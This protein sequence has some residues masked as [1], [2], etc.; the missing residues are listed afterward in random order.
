MI[1]RGLRGRGRG[2]HTSFSRWQLAHEWI[3]DGKVVPSSSL[4]SDEIDGVTT[5]PTTRS[6]TAEKKK[7]VLIFLHGL[8]GNSKNLHTPAKRLT[9][10][11]GPEY[12]A[13]LLDVR[14]HGQSS[15]STFDRPHSFRN[16]VMDIFQTLHPLGLVGRNSPMAICGHSLGGRIAL[17][18]S[19]TTCL[20]TAAASSASSANTKEK[21]EE[22]SSDADNNSNHKHDDIITFAQQFQI[23]KQ[24]WVL[25]SVPGV[26]DPSVHG[27]LRAI[28]SIPIPVQ[29]KKWLVDTLIS[30]PY[31]LELHL[32]RWI[33][34]NLQH[35]KN[36]A[37]GGLQWVF[38]LDIANELIMNFDNQDFKKM[39]SNITTSDPSPSSTSSSSVHLV[40]AGKN[41]NWTEEIVLN[42]KSIHTYRGEEESSSLYPPSS[43]FQMHKLEN[44][45]HWVH[46]DDLEGLLR[47]MI[48]EIQ[49]L[50]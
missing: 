26:A 50:R 3:V 30:K 46:V 28:T 41:K 6:T 10:A 25:D 42:L 38:D 43:S 19:Y 29:S 18:Y 24:T 2:F 49:R 13:L 39:I 36:D 14:G 32:S 37:L 5:Y 34:T 20:A 8:L 23:P 4:S 48:T 12:A 15:S 31:N 35:D 27:V 7:E 21:V 17:E 1:I 40:M 9:R 11:L 22:D 16:C 44:S 47:L 33:M 45:G